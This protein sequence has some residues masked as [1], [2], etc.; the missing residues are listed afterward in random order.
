M[1]SFGLNKKV[2]TKKMMNNKRVK[3]HTYPCC[4]AR[5]A[6]FGYTELGERIRT[7]HNLYHKGSFICNR[8]VPRKPLYH[9]D[10]IHNLS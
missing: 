5:D 6:I 8:D 3:W 10:E 2:R 7:K 4:M 1:I 9:M